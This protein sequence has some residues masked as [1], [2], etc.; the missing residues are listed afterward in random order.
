M[1]AGARDERTNRQ[2]LNLGG[3]DELSVREI[4]DVI[5]EA[6]GVSVRDAPWPELAARIESGDT[7]FDA[8]RLEKWIGSDYQHRFQAWVR[9]ESRNRSG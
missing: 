5:A 2:V 1:V 4:A 7:V 8:T 3:P 6:Y 9:G